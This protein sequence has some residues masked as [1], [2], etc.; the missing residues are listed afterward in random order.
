MATKAGLWNASPLSS[1]ELL[2]AMC[3]SLNI[4]F[5]ACVRMALG[6]CCLAAVKLLC[7]L[8]F[9]RVWTFDHLVPFDPS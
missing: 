7:L 1:L 2:L 3:L 6:S 8:G 9:R 4:N 5:H